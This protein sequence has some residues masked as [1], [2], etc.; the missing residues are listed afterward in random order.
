MLVYQYVRVFNTGISQF[1]TQ[2]SYIKVELNV[3]VSV[4]QGIYNMNTP[5]YPIIQLYTIMM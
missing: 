4:H 1:V 3:G 2:N 5:L